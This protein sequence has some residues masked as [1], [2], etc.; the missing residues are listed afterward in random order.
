MTFM[1][2][3]SVGN[4]IIPTDVHSMIFQGRYTTNQYDYSFPPLTYI[5]YLRRPWDDFYGC[6]YGGHPARSIRGKSS[7]TVPTLKPRPDDLTGGPQSVEKTI[8]VV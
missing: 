8:E 5:K 6:V 1:T 4:V 7:W 3:H 2:S